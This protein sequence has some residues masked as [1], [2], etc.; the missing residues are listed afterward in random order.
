MRV[1][2]TYGTVRTRTN[3]ALVLKTLMLR[4]EIQSERALNGTESKNS[5]SL[6]KNDSNASM[7]S[8]SSCSSEP[9]IIPILPSLRRVAPFG[10][11]PRAVREIKSVTHAN[12][13]S[14][15]RAP[16]L[17]ARSEESEREYS[18]SCSSLKGIKCNEFD[19]ANRKFDKACGNL[20]R[21]SEPVVNN[22]RD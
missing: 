13:A 14:S 5:T 22:S 4:A 18:T 10:A 9:V 21:C 11:H 19:S 12:K 20:T 16:V 7:L 1:A 3:G 2:N 8:I 17:R 15:G 6:R